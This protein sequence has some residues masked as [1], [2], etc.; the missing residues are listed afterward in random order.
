MNLFESFEN[1]IKEGLISKIE[2]NAT[3]KLGDFEQAARGIYYT[4]VAGLIRRSNSDMSAGML[5]NQILE[6]F[7]ANEL[8]EDFLNLLSKKEFV[9]KVNVEGAKIISQIFPAY[10]SPLLSMISTYSGT[11][12]NTTVLC[13]GVTAI[14]LVDLLGKKIKAETMTKNDLIFFLKQHHEP[15]FKEAPELLMEKMIPTL[16]LQEL[17]FMKTTN[18]KKVEEKEEENGEVKDN[19]YLDFLAGGDEPLFSKK[20]MI[21]LAVLV[22]VLA[23][24]YYLWAN[25]TFTKDT[26]QA[27]AIEEE[28]IFSDSLDA[29]NAAV[30]SAALIKKD[31]LAK[32]D[33]PK[34]EM[35]ALNNYLFDTT[36]PTGKVFDFKSISFLDGS[37]DLTTQSIPV[38]ESLAEAMVGNQSLQ[39]KIIGYE[40]LGDVKLSNKRA[41][42]IKKALME[43]GVQ[44]IRI[45]AG[46]GGKGIGFPQI[47]VITK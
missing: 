28:L 34:S 22:A 20:V 19:K 17:T 11:S 26:T 18:L 31:T 29:G 14:I 7:S 30:D 16:G 41:F 27:E 3:D 45:D 35:E 13:S 24:G 40:P 4:L 2:S 33:L 8:P 12:K 43:N 9:T 47:K 5:Y 15:L 10:K 42:A 44:T 46:S 25:G 32:V 36:T 38:I 1:I 23:L 39:V 6:K 21:G 37:P